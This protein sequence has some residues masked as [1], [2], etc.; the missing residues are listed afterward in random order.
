MNCENFAVQP[1]PYG[2]DALEP[3]IDEWTLRVH[4]DVLYRRYVE[5]L[6]KAL[7]KYPQYCGYTLEELILNVDSL[8]PEI[9]TPVF[10][11]AGGVYN[12]QLYF[13][14]MQPAPSREPQGPLAEA[15]N[16]CFRSFGGFKEAFTRKALDVF[17]SGYAWLAINHVGMLEITSTANQTTVLTLNMYPLI[18]IDV[19]EH[20]YFCQYSAE[21]ENYI[22][23]WFQV[24]N[25]QMAEF[26]LT[27]Q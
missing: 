25:W 20:A 21:R 11:N 27:G 12:H 8:P 10:H 15:I 7:E 2:Y 23:S 18:G 19:W 17:G 6:N 24:A 1:L 9:Q 22:N 14:T 4:H 13:E 16:Q 3:Y 5:N 26:R